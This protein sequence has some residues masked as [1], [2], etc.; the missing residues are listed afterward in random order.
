M[1][2]INH[3]LENKIKEE[4]TE[5]SIQRPKKPRSQA[6]IEATKKMLEGR[7]KWA[8]NKGK[9]NKAKKVAKLK[10]KIAKIDPQEVIDDIEE[11]A[12]E[13]LSSNPTI[14]EPMEQVEEK[15][16]EAP[17]P[18]LKQ[19][20]KPKKKKVK[21]VVNNYHYPQ[22]ESDEDEEEII[23]NNYYIPPKKKTKKKKVVKKPPTPPSSEEE[24]EEYTDNPSLN[25][26]GYS[27]PPKTIRFV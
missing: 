16:I 15:V 2:D 10:E 3:K 13:V 11:E 7:K 23:T 14:D 20:A 27:P 24:E 12:K 25:G 19:K 21:Q 5:K 9:E 8:E 22:E 4:D 1:A 17:K 6:Q 18:I 26:F